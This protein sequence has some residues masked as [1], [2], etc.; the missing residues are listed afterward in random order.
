MEDNRMTTPQLLEVAVQIGRKLLESGAE[1]YRVEESVCRICMAYGAC[2]AHVFAVP[3]SIVATVERQDEAPLTRT[4]RIRKRG[5]D[6]DRVAQLNALSRELCAC[7]QDYAAVQQLL[8]NI[9]AAPGY[10]KMTLRLA[11]GAISGFFTL[12][13]GGDAMSALVA[14]AT[15]FVL[16]IALDG[17]E[18]WDVNSIFANMVGGAIIAAVAALAT[19]IGLITNYDRVIIGSI[20]TLVPGLAITNSMRDLIAG[21]MLAGVTKFSEAL[22]IGASI[23]AGA[24]I[25]LGVFRHIWRG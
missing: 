25:S 19:S 22:L 14:F 4:C 7:Q 10:G 9:D 2:D 21:D 18:R 15:G 13:F 1:T 11:F 5:V 23:A 24:S 16:K 8:R 20:M 12:L 3:T 6:L 17:L